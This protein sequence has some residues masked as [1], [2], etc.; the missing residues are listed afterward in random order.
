[1][2]TELTHLDAEGKARM[3]DVGGK[4]PVVR[5]AVAAGRIRISPETAD[6][7]R[8]NNIQKGDVLATAR[9][10]GIAAGKRTPDLIPL[11]HTVALDALNV[12]LQVDEHA[13]HIRAE[14]RATDRT[15]VEM[16]ALTAVSAAAL[17]IY[18]MCKA[19]DKDMEISEIHLVEKSKAVQSSVE[20]T[21]PLS[22]AFTVLSVNTSVRKGE[23]KQP[24]KSIRLVP[25]HGI[26]G[27]AHAGPGDRQIS[28]LA[29]RDIDTMRGK[30][31]ELKAGDFAEN[32]TVSGVEP[33]SL[34]VGTK[35]FIGSA[36]LE[37]S[38]IGKECH[39][40]CE[41][42]RIVGDCVMPRAGVFARVIKGGVVNDGDTGVYY[43]R[44]GCPG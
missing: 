4:P 12:D 16:E 3:V 27:D 29:E 41:I 34:P 32:L 30:G 18:D 6:L 21:S 38:K 37:I 43:F 11:C 44:P 28:I 15:G 23:K 14:A 25:E 8:G 24:C 33:A 40:G 13:V 2:K 35:L 26:E 5:T 31:L 10:A 7:I 19:V 42:R 39:H 9:I 1:M 36:I 20:H 22:G 17:T